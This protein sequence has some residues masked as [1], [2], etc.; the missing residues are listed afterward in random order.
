M[1][2]SSGAP[3]GG[4]VVIATL[5]NG[6]PTSFTHAIAGNRH[7]SATA[8]PRVHFPSSREISFI[9]AGRIFFNL[10]FLISQWGK[11]LG[12][13]QL[14]LSLSLHSKRKRIFLYLQLKACNNLQL[15]IPNWQIEPAVVA[16]NEVLQDKYL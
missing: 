6:L 9:S 8:H 5:S 14:S 4:D 7:C 12:K 11:L 16:C 13:L 15:H 10:T 3:K 2:K 1:L